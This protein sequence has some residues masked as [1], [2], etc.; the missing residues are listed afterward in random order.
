MDLGQ[1][2]QEAVVLFERIGSR[3]GW[4]PYLASMADQRKNCTIR[5]EVPWHDMRVYPKVSGLRR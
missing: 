1:A 3:D 5:T 4:G 2:M